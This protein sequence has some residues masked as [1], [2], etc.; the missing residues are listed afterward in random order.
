MYISS[1]WNTAPQTASHP[2]L[3]RIDHLHPFFFVLRRTRRIYQSSDIRP[4]YHAGELGKVIGIYSDR[5]TRFHFEIMM[6]R[7]PPY[8]S[9]PVMMGMYGAQDLAFDVERTTPLW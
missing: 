2:V 3:G 9:N 6:D 1:V 8:Y 5:G 7:P 4:L